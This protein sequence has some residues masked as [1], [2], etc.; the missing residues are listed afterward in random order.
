[1]TKRKN[2]NKVVVANSKGKAKVPAT[3]QVAPAAVATKK[4]SIAPK[5]QFKQDG[6][7][8]VGHYEYM[9]DVDAGSTGYTESVLI[10][11]QNSTAFTW[12]SALATRFEMYKFRKL[13]FH[14]KPSTGTDTAGWIVVGFDFDAY[15]AQTPV[16]S[17]MLAWKYSQKCAPW[18]SSSVNV[19]PDSRMTTYRYCDSGV[20][21]S[22]GDIRLDYLGRL[23]V[24]ASTTS[25]LAIGEM[26]VEYVVEFRQPALKIPA[27]LYCSVDNTAPMATDDD[28]FNTTSVIVG[29]LLAEIVDSKTLK[30]NQKGKFLIDLMTDATGTITGGLSA[31]LQQPSGSPSARGNLTTFFSVNDTAAA[32][33]QLT[34]K[35]D[36]D[37]PPMNLVLGDASGDNIAR[38]LK[39]ATYDATNVL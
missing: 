16:K 35:V 28:W 20:I 14:Y 15:D 33:Q 31:I 22:R 1:M 29:N 24:L 11:P 19:S 38:W 17:D 23:T 36:V 6:S 4:K 39:I 18:Q 7:C 5:V 3:M 26:Y 21:G 12:L 8:T 32:R 37:T 34:V 2:N 25:T 30:L 27:P 13:I 9:F 10:N